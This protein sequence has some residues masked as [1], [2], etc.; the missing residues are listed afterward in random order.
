MGSSVPT[1]VAVVYEF[2][3]VELLD[4]ELI[5][6]DRFLANRPIRKDVRAANTRSDRECWVALFEFDRLE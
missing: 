1:R 4:V 6:Q 3:R 5:L 2:D